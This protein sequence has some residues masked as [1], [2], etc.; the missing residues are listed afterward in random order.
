MAIAPA[1]L[2]GNAVLNYSVDLIFADEWSIG[3]GF[4]HLLQGKPIFEE[5]IAQQNDSRLFFPKLLFFGLAALNNFQY[6]TFNN[7][8][9]IFL[10]AC[11]ISINIF[12][13]SRLTLPLRF[14]QQFLLFAIANLFIF[15][16]MQWENWNWGI[17]LIVF[18][19]I[20]CITSA[21][22]ITQ[23][24]LDFSAI[25]LITALLGTLSTFSYANGMLFWVI[26]FPALL[27]AKV[28]TVKQLKQ[29]NVTRWKILSLWLLYAALNIGYFFYNYKKTGYHTNL[30]EVLKKNPAD[31]IHYFL[32]FL[33][34]P[35]GTESFVGAPLKQGWFIAQV[36][37]AVLLGC[38]V[39]IGIAV[40]RR[41]NNI[42]WLQVVYPWLCI[43]FYTLLSAVLTTMGRIGLGVTQSLSSRYNT[44]SAYGWI[45]A[46]YLVAA[47]WL[48]YQTVE[49][50][51][52]KRSKQFF[53]IATVGLLITL[54]V[55]Q[56]FSW[57]YGLRIMKVR[58]RERLYGKAC[59][60]AQNF[61]VEADCINAYA[62]PGF[63]INPVALSISQQLDRLKA[64]KPGLITAQEFNEAVSSQVSD[65]TLYGY[66]DTATSQDAGGFF[67]FGGWS[68]LP[69]YKYPAHGVMLLALNAQGTPTPFAIAPV[70]KKRPDVK[71][72]VGTSEYR[73]QRFG[74]EMNVPKARIPADA[75]Q[76]IA[77]AIDTHTGN[78]HRLLGSSQ[79]KRST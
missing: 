54:L 79:L 30:L 49:S 29:I 34:A 53:R 76:V 38:Y 57:N 11:F 7:C 69:E 27:A 10:V 63:N 25:S 28:P 22:V 9:L 13:L 68:V 3:L 20:A 24:R 56:F 64:W 59:L 23:L 67:K 65:S 16:P 52:T 18:I 66:I 50:F 62:S 21:L 44:F 77:L 19:P 47:L 4:I 8:I 51:R 32:A 39:W 60:L 31:V 46:L 71:Q 72:V 5:L 48:S 78:L 1:I 33:G 14:W 35:L 6:N 36:M 41:R 17:Q 42:G 26:I 12:V 73:S 70:N 55:L 61:F 43:G 74:W 40:W 15:S 75:T 2:L 37:G 58:H 45:A